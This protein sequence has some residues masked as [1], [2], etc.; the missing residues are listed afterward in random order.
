MLKYFFMKHHPHDLSDVFIHPLYKTKQFEYILF[1]LFYIHY[2]DATL[3][4]AKT[5]TQAFY[6]FLTGN[7]DAYRAYQ[8]CCATI[9][10]C[11]ILSDETSV[12]FEALDLLEIDSPEYLRFAS[13]AESLV[14]ILEDDSWDNFDYWVQWFEERELFFQKL[15]FQ[16][17][18]WMTRDND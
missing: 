2:P 7:L 18:V 11:F 1:Q 9:L 14:S 17:F 13:L 15:I 4:E 12:L 10:L 16:E 5:A 3:E 8:Q 6:N